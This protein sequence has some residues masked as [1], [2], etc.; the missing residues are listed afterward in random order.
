MNPQRLLSLITLVALVVAPGSLVG[1]TGAAGVGATVAPAEIVPATRARADAPPDADTNWFATAQ[2]YIRRSEYQV[3]W[4]EQTVLPDL[5]AAYQAPNRAHNL[6]TYFTPTGVRV[7]PRTLTPNPSPSQGEGQRG[8]DWSFG[9]RLTAFGPTDAPQPV[10]NPMEL[11]AEEN[12]FTYRFQGAGDR[13]QGTGIREQYLNDEQGL[14]QSF[15]IPAPP[16]GTDGC[17]PRQI[18][19][20]IAGDLIPRLTADG[21]AIEFTTADGA[22]ILRYGDLR[23]RDATGRSLIADL[24]LQIADCTQ[25]EIWAWFRILGS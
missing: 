8:G 4:Q 2:D 20:D 7:V 21:A 25:S 15:I 14:H 3:T 13:G 24:R 19:L 22:P 11:R 5:S 10:G 6:R 1:R 23:A 17:P 12:R 9:L 16:A 18:A